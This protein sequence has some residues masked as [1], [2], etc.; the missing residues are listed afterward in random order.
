VRVAYILALFRG[1]H[2][3]PSSSIKGIGERGDPTLVCPLERNILSP[4]ARGLAGI[5]Q[6]V[7]R[8]AT[9]WADRES[10]PGGDEIFPT[11]PDRHW[12][13][14]SLLQ[15]A[16]RVIN[17]CGINHS[18]SPSAEVKERIQLYMYSPPSPRALMALSKVNFAFLPLPWARVS[19]PQNVTTFGLRRRKTFKISVTTSLLALPFT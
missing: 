12:G 13:L 11:R 17:G 10:N 16:Y 19:S 18:P 14:L 1:L 4:W 9:G 5:P 2:T 6:S 8:L 15:N 7:Q 3:S